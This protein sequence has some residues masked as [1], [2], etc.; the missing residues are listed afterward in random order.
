VYVQVVA[1]GSFASGGDIAKAIACGAD[2]VMVG[3]PLAAANEAPGRGFNW[4]SA[5]PHPSLPR[6]TRVEVPRQGSL[7]EILV[8]PAHDDG[9]RTNLFGALRS[10]MASCGYATVREFHKAEVM[11]APISSFDDDVAPVTVSP[12]DQGRQ[13]RAS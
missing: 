5:A 13:G 7:E 11:V 10:A 1:D 3:S 8:G 12:S 2:A 4:G 6:G 9:G